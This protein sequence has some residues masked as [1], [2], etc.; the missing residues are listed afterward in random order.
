MVKKSPKIVFLKETE[1]L[2]LIAVRAFSDS[3]PFAEGSNKL[4]CIASWTRIG[5]MKLS[6]NVRFSYMN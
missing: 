3:V 2:C 4:I 1:I 5:V 6:I